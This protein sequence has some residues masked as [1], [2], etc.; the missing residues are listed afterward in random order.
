MLIIPAIDLHDGKCV[1]L[2]QGKLDEETV[3][4]ENPLVVARQ[5]VAAGAKMLH[6]VD[7]NGAFE[8]SPTNL[9]TIY[10]IAQAIPI[11]VQ[12]GGGIRSRCLVENMFANKVARVVLGTTAI[13][14][15]ELV[16]QLIKDYPQ[17]IVLGIDAN[18]GKVAVKGW[19]EVT[20]LKATDLAARFKGLP[21]AG[22]VFTDIDRDGTLKGHNLNSLKLMIQSTD[23]S[24][25]ASG[26]IGSIDDIQQVCKKFPRAIY[27]II[28]G[29]ALYTGAVDL[30]EAVEKYQVFDNC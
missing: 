3:F 5:W 16:Q 13:T 29:R 17:K 27:G 28:V 11:P 24:I 30:K 1:R 7:L 21:L 6:L 20:Y 9:D 12:V 19:T 26:G 4:S 23:A 15:P 22:I 8:G 14:N 25:I 2:Y 10:R 18:D